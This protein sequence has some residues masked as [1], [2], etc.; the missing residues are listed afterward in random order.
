IGGPSAASIGRSQAGRG[1]VRLGP[2]EML[3]FQAALST[4]TTARSQVGAVEVRP[5]TFGAQ[6]CER[7]SA[8]VDDDEGQSDLK[9][10]VAAAGA[11][12]LNGGIAAPRRPWLEPLA[13]RLVL[14]ELA[15][16]CITDEHCV[17]DE[18]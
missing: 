7:I 17:A 13:D 9:L 16:Y 10:L 6:P 2:G 3:P 5:F 18:R 12:A 11:A 15:E 1:F 8:T 4:G 14:D